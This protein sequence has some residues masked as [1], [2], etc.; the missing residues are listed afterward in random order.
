MSWRYMWY[1]VLRFCNRI[2]SGLR[3][4][5]CDCLWLCFGAGANSRPRGSW[6]RV[7]LFAWLRLGWLLWFKTVRFAWLRSTRLLCFLV[8]CWFWTL[9]SDSHRSWYNNCTSS[10]VVLNFASWPFQVLLVGGRGSDRSW[11]QPRRPSLH[12]CLLIGC[13]SRD[14]SSWLC[15][16]NL[17]NSDLGSLLGWSFRLSCCGCCKVWPGRFLTRGSCIHVRC[18]ESCECGPR[19]LCYWLF[20]LEVR[21]RGEVDCFGNVLRP[22]CQ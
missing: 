17:T 21:L 7:V 9:P 5:G 10:W 6:S 13:R 12:W 15:S 3:L 19:S 16:W 1:V 22:C 4:L 20:L 18:A 14:R 8:V 2:G 11:R